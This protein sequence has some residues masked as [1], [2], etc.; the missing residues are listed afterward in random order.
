MSQFYISAAHKSSG[1]TTISIGL[2]AALSTSYKLQ[3]FKKGPD[4]IDP[5]WLQQA[6]GNPVYNLD[7]Y[8]SSKNY[9]VNQYHHYQ[10][11]A[12]IT[13]IEGNKGLFDGLNVDG[14]DSNAAMAKLL[15][16]PVILVL[17]CQGI[18]RG[19][20]PLIQGYVNFEKDIEFAGIILN[21]VAGSRHEAKLL[22]AISTYTDLP[23]LGSVRRHKNLEIEERHLGLVPNSELNADSIH[24]INGLRTVISDSVNLD[25][26]TQNISLIKEKPV[27]A[28][29]KN[30]RIAIAKDA[31][32]GFYYASDLAYF[33]QKGVELIEF[34]TLKDKQLPPNIDALIIGGGFP[35]THLD[36]LSANKTMLLDIKQK[37]H[38][39]LPAYA[40]C[41]GL[42]YLCESIEYQTQIKPMV[43]IIPE[44]ILMHPKPQGRGYIKVKPTKDHPWQPEK[45]IISGH[46]FH[47]SSLKSNPSNAIYSYS[48]MRGT[49]INQQNDGIVIHN[50]IA[51]YCHLRQTD[52]CHWIDDFILFIKSIKQ[53]TL[54]SQS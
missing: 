33:K 10:Q 26:F 35:E 12:E 48:M 41:G 51:N 38:Q 40:E 39:G 50:L 52:Q 3:V 44:S 17:D 21:K 31:S 45:K 7:F 49:G 24:Y 37:I 23:V 2:S 29:N 4:Y 15:K 43:G 8:T 25:F 19:I 20:A 30:L 9:I 14:S 1:K 5:M 11:Q 42:M 27:R 28:S 6:S 13:L 36:Q 34:N 22:S 32:F 46:E 47:Y 16:T 53:K 54:N 18:T